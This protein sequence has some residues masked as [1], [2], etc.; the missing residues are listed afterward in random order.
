MTDTTQFLREFQYFIAHQKELVQKH[1][2]KFV[3]I[4]NCEVIGVYDNELEAITETQK[5]QE[6]GTFL[7]QVCKPGKESYTQTYHSRV[8]V[9]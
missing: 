9:C 5:V 3:V 8:M 1:K 4:K 2:D 6:L 7:V